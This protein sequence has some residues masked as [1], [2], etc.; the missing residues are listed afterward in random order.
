MQER[1]TSNPYKYTC[2]MVISIHICVQDGL[3]IL[4]VSTSSL[5]W[6]GKIIQWLLWGSTQLWTK[7]INQYVGQANIQSLL[8][9]LTNGYNYSHMCV[10]WIVNTVGDYILAFQACKNHMVAIFG[11]LLNC[12]QH[13]NINMQ[14]R[15]TS[16][17]YKYT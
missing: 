4:L 12:G 3:C 9:H 1:Q 16:N 6:P 14:V 13:A 5:F 17:P 8:I 2:K 10:G 11:G 7:C 15:Q